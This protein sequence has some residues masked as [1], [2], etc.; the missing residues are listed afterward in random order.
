MAARHDFERQPGIA[1]QRA[2]GSPDA[3]RS[4]SVRCAGGGFAGFVGGVYPAAEDTAAAPAIGVTGQ[5]NARLEK[6]LRAPLGRIIANADSINARADGPIDPHYAD[7]AADIAHAGRH[8]LGLFVDDLVDLEAIERDDFTV[9]AEPMDLAIRCRRAAALLSVRATDGD[10]T[11][12]RG[13]MQQPIPALGE[14]RRTLQIMVNLIGN[15][16]RY[17]PRGGTIWLRLQREGD[18]VVA[19][20]ADQGRGA[21]RG[22]SGAGVREVRARRSGRAGGQRPRPLHRAAAGAA[23]GGDLTDS[24]PGMGARFVLSLRRHIEPS[25]SP[26][27]ARDQY[28]QQ[29]RDRQPGAVL[30]PLPLGDHGLHCGQ[31]T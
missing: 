16:V 15:A 3:R 30:S 11:I 25:A 31:R 17:S 21:R 9:E 4:R 7:Y 28:Q 18:H 19:I 14:F 26:R 24:A 27:P 8:L 5:F 10:V 13:E 2:R 20:V 1:P 6:A 12:D 23:M 22:G 29:P